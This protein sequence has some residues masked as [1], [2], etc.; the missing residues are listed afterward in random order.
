MRH[1]NRLLTSLT[2]LSAAAALSACGTPEAASDVVAAR[3]T[4]PDFLGPAAL[5]RQLGGAF[6][7]GLEQLAVMNQPPEDAADL[8]QTLPTG[9]LHSFVCAAPSARP[10]NPAA[11]WAWR[12]TASW[13]TVDGHAQRTAYAVRLSGAGCFVAHADPALHQVRD[14][15]IKSFAQH[16]LDRLLSLKPGC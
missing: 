6:R 1:S 8:G 16:P 14:T 5:E 7:S 11:A 12:C 15:T 9:R 13:R 3:P 10:T 4:T 2:A